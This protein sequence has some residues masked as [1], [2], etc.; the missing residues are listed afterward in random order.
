MDERDEIVTGLAREAAR[1]AYGKYR[2]LVTNNE[3]PEHR[4]RL[5]LQVPA[6]LGDAET[7]WALPCLPFG[8]LAGHGWFAVPEVAA[9]VWVEFEEGD[10]SRPI[11]T[12][13]FWQQQGDAPEEAA[14]T[15]PT[16]R[17]LKTPRGHRLELD[18]KEG[19][20]RFLLHHP[21]GTELAIDQDGGVQLTGA[22]GAR[23]TLDARGRKI[24]IED[25]NDNQIELAAA[26][27]TV[28]GQ[29][30]VIAGAQLVTL[31]GEGGEPILKG[32]SFL[33]LFATHVHPTPLGAPASGPPVPQGETL[34]L[35][36]KVLTS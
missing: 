31:G 11:W 12:G 20:E 6:V 8:G 4:A 32:Q 10:P 3:D 24:Q 19:A 28:S 27:I 17:L 34:T 21:A 15:P 29:K 23:V 25:G 1:R 35:S 26:G 18:D 9:Q 33:T 2:G 5:R 36:T 30:V 13:T 14:V 16:V 22:G 7:G